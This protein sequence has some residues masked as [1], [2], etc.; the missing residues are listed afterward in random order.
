[1]NIELE[2]ARLATTWAVT[3]KRKDAG[4]YEDLGRRITALIK[5]AI[6]EE[7]ESCAALCAGCHHSPLA[8]AIR[9]RIAK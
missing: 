7:N 9:N 5:A 6:A 1:M 8:N 4:A 2:A 3:H